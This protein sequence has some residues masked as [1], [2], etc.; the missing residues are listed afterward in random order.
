MPIELSKE[1]HVIRYQATLIL[2]SLASKRSQVGCLS[3]ITIWRLWLMA[4][5]GVPVS[6]SHVRVNNFDQGLLV[7]EL[8]T[9]GPFVS[10]EI[11]VGILC[12]TFFIVASA[13]TVKFDA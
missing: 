2:M 6:Y 11:Y 1:C 13:L 4:K 3:I 9:A 5:K 10:L 7:E 8:Q 12:Y